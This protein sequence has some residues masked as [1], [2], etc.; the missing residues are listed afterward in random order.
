M[1]YFTEPR[2]LCILDGS[3]I[4]TCINNCRFRYA[5]RDLEAELFRSFTLF[6]SMKDEGSIGTLGRIFHFVSERDFQATSAGR[7]RGFDFGTWAL[8]R[9]AGRMPE[10]RFRGT[11]I[12]FSGSMILGIDS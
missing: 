11:M 5:I 3:C 12:T 6:S 7:T 2:G 4:W 8:M 1:R 10:V 9:S